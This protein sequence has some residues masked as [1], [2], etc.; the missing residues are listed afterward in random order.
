MM[1][2]DTWTLLWQR[3]QRY[4][5]VLPSW[6]SALFFW[7]VFLH[8]LGLWRYWRRQETYMALGTWFLAS[9]SF[10]AMLWLKPVAHALGAPAVGVLGVGVQC[11]NEKVKRINPDLRLALWI[12]ILILHYI[13]VMTLLITHVILYLLGRPG[14]ALLP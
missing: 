10:L 14:P 3:G 1:D 11:L 12:K 7:I 9:T 4:V 8:L 13:A 6:A 2:G 5:E